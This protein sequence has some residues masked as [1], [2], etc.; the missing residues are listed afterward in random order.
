MCQMH[1]IVETCSILGTCIRQ[2]MAGT[3]ERIYAKITRKTCLVL[4]SYE[5]ECQGRREQ[6]T[7]GA[8]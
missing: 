5:F 7:H 3:T 6:T 1:E 8:L 4:G 2:R